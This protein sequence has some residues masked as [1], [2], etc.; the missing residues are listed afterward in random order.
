MSLAPLPYDPAAVSIGVAHLGPGAFHR[1]HQAWY[2]HRLLASDPTWGI[3]AISLRSDDLRAALEPQNGLYV[4]TELDAETRFET[5]GVHREILTAPREPAAV[6]A[7]LADPATRIVTLTITEKGYCLA[8][9]GTL[10]FSHPDIAADLANSDRPTS[11]IGWLAQGLSLRRAAGNAPF[12]VVSCDN[13]P[14]NGHRLRAAVLALSARRDPALAAWIGVNVRFPRTMVDSITPAADEALRSRVLAET[15]FADAWPIQRE[16]F[17]QW[18]IEDLSDPALTPLAEVGVTFTPD[19]A[20]F[21]AAK[22]RLLNGPHSTLAYLGLA[23]GHET[24]AEA[25]ADPALAAFTEALMREDI[26]PF[27]R[28]APGL[29][30]PAYIAAVLARFRNPAIRHRLAQI[31]W[32]GS[33]K[34]PIRLMG[35]AVEALAAGA[36]IDRLAVPIAAW[37]RFVITAAKTGQ[38][39]TDPLADRLLALGRTATGPDPCLDLDLV[40]AALKSSPAFRAAVRAAFDRLPELP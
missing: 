29:D 27:V 35:T 5:I 7:R 37:A 8:P 13:I 28:P 15:G 24:V 31:A 10:D 17:C 32:D 9:D 22:L 33:Q 30:I 1:A 12:T 18:V 34:L 20:G 11:A 25:M 6:L 21:E 16:A 2:F 14:D 38:P 23:R 40:P 36:R 3:S 26:A 39:I 19:V 4:L